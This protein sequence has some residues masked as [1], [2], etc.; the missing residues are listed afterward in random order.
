MFVIFRCDFQVDYRLR[1]SFTRRFGKR[2]FT[3]EQLQQF[4]VP[5]RSVVTTDAVHRDPITGKRTVKKVSKVMGYARE[6]TTRRL[7]GETWKETTEWIP[8]TRHME[9]DSE[10]WSRQHQKGVEGYVRIFLL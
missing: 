5:V 7:V 4:E 1:S 8:V 9:I 3:R 6:H 10:T 2:G